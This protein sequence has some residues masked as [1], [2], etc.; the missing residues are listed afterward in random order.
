MS[1]VQSS[2]PIGWQS[3]ISSAVRL[4]AMIPAMRAVWNT[5]PLAVTMSAPD[6]AWSA[7]F[8]PAP[9]SRSRTAGGSDTSARAVAVRVVAPLAETSTMRGS[10]AASRC[11]KPDPPA[12]SAA[13][14]VHL[15]LGV[16]GRFLFG[17]IGRPAVA[18]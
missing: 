6:P 14:M 12:G 15:D 11:V 5:G 4:A 8:P 16:L 13:D 3:G 18:A 17:A 2:R 9:V 10:P 1:I 7:P